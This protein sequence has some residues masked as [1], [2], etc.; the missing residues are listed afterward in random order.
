MGNI[1]TDP[2]PTTF[3]ENFLPTLVRDFGGFSVLFSKCCMI[4][5]CKWLAVCFAVCNDLGN[6]YITDLF[7]SNI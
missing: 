4:S 7:Q 2:S 1:R 5:V 3:S 6:I